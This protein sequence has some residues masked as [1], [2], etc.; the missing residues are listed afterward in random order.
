MDVLGGDL[1]PHGVILR[2]V[3]RDVDVG[4][5]GVP[6]L[7]G[8]VRVALE[9]DGEIR[10]LIRAHFHGPLVA[11]VFGTPR[12]DEFVAPDRETG[13]VVPIDVEGEAVLGGPPRARVHP[14][15][16]HLVHEPV[17]EHG[18]LGGERSAAGLV[19]E[20][21][22]GGDGTPARRILDREAQHAMGGRDGRG[23]AALDL[24]V[25]QGD[26]L[27]A[28]DGE[29]GVADSVRGET[30]ALERHP[31]RGERRAGRGA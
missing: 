31:G 21:E 15:E 7:G 8:E 5:A 11:A 18:S 30:G 12:R 23:V 1:C 10:R 4:V 16:S 19:V 22:P 14:Q 13:L 2:M 27:R 9:G 17:H 20:T 24:D 6:A 26:P 28:A 29:V 3:A 25:A